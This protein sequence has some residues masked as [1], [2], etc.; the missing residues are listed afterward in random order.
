MSD[1]LK[2]RILL[3]GAGYMA[4]EYCKVLIE[5][6]VN[7]EV[8]GKSDININKLRNIYNK[9]IFYSGGLE[10]YKIGNEIYTHAIIASAVEKLSDHA[11]ILLNA[12]IKNILL[13]KPGD[14]NTSCLIEL[15]KLAEKLYA[16]IWVAYNRRFY[17]S[18]RELK[19]Q[20]K[21]D[22]G[23]IST[24]FEFTEWV[25]TIDPNIYN[26]KVLNKWIIANSS[27][28]IDTVFYLIGLPKS[29]NSIVLGQNQ[30]EW[31]PS[32]SI[33]IGSGI[34]EQGIPFTYHSNWLSSGS[35]AVEILTSKRRFYL[36][37]M[38]KLF[39]Q[40]IETIQ[41]EE[42]IIDNEKDKKY[43]PGLMD[44]TISF[45]KCSETELLGI[46]KHIETMPYYMKIGG[47]C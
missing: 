2:K 27:H 21:L 20:V 45:I 41:L 33:F 5:L 35:W 25:H 10:N 28:V 6:Q 8:V 31:H 47:Y 44:Q 22:G 46:T 15:K 9:N 38:E 40:N 32:G 14:L 39:V 24:H 4:E 42:F 34:S 12:G 29:L 18:V 37:P 26:N 17:S 7:F 11:K 16:K 36:K 23:I 30:I 1:Y 13:E 3:V 43:K 19:K